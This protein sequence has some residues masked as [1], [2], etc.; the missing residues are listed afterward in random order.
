MWEV[1][2]RSTRQ[3]KPTLQNQGLGHVAAAGPA[4]EPHGW[5]RQPQGSVR[6]DTSPLHHS[7]G[8]SF[9]LA[10]LL[11]QVSLNS[12]LRSLTERE[13]LLKRA[14]EMGQTDLRETELP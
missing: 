4:A 13:A 14:Q 11:S 8:E 1:K 7:N 12:G 5:E 9:P 2:L 3:G 6:A 10:S